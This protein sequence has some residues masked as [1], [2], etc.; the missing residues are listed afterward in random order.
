ML[1]TLIHY[2]RMNLAV[3][4]GAAVAT[5]VLTGALLVGDSVRGS[6][7]YLTLE[8]LGGVDH[9]LAGQRFFHADV[10]ER[11][12]QETEFQ[13]SFAAAA[14]AILLQG[15]ALHAERRTRASAVGLQGIDERFLEV[16]G[17]AGG[18]EDFFSG[19]KG[20]FPPAVI[21]ESLRAALQ[22]EVGDAILVSLKRWSEV[23]RGSV[24]GRKDT[25]SVVGT[26]RL[27]VARV[28]ADRGIGRFALA[29][30]QSSPYNVFVPLPALQKALDQEDTVNSLVVG[31]A[32][33]EGGATL[34]GLLQKVI[35]PSDL[36]LLIEERSGVLSLESQEFI[37]NPSLIRT[38]GALAA[39]H[40]APSLPILTYLANGIAIDDRR[41][42]YSTVTATETGSDSFGV[43]RLLDGSPA[44]EL[45][46]GEILLNAWTAEDLAAEV[47]DTVELSYYE[48]GPREELTEARAALRLRGILAMEG[49]AVDA[50]LSQEYPGIAGNEN[51]ADWDPPFPIDLNDIRVQDEDYWDT[52]RGTPKAFIATGTGQR[53]W[54]NRWGDLTAIRLAPPAGQDL[55][56]FR[57]DVE[58]RL[59]Q[60]LSLDAF[61]LTFQP[62]KQL[63]LQASAGSSDYGGYFIGFSFFLI[64]AAAM[65]V[66]L[67][68]GLGVEQ[69]AAEIGLLQAV[70]YAS[71]SVRRRLLLEG[72]LLAACG[73]LVGLVGAVGYAA[74]MM[75]AFRTWWRPAFGT[76]EL[77]LHVTP[78]SLVVGYLLSVAV[79]LFAIWRRVRQLRQVPTPALLKRV[80]EPVDTRAGRRARWT[81]VI[82]LGLA[83]VLLSIA[84]VTGETRNALI[85]AIAGPALLVG[86]LAAFALTLGGASR[87]L[88][89]PGGWTLLRM[90]AANG[91]RSKRR[92][93]LSATLV[94]AASFL[95]V[96]VAAFHHDFSLEELGKDSGS[97]GYALIGESDVPL[98]RDLS[99]RD[100]RFELGLDEAAEAVLAESTIT[101]LRL[102]PGDDTSC[103]NL[104]QPREPRLLGVP[105]EMIRRG[106]FVFQNAIQEADNPWSL[107]EQELEDGV[108]P[109]IGDV[110]S[111]Q[112]ILKLGLGKD[113]IL[114]N[115]RGEDVRIRLVANLKTS[116]FQSELL[117][118]QNNFAEHFPDQE[119]ASVFLIETPSAKVAETTQVLESSLGAYGFDAV[120]TIEKLTAFHAVQNTFLSTFRTLGGLGLLLGTVGLAIVLLRNV[121]ERRG[122]LAA[123]RAFG[124]RR[125]TL[126]WMVL[127]ENGL[128]LVAGLVIGTT[129]ALVT[130]GPHLLSAGATVPWSQILG[131]LVVILVFGLAACTAA[132]LG[133]L[134]IP[135]LPALKAEH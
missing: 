101:P 126:T 83:L 58:R 55:A 34:D 10:A 123:L 88:E 49:L 68:F 63:G 27:E 5:A 57:T 111:T 103:L 133:A 115:G 131:T 89:R 76:S 1:R 53:L 124:Y 46:D 119:G 121:I 82:A 6:L 102:L 127:V 19:G 75:V 100:G 26:V 20:I 92:S 29:A 71:G 132:S 125:A 36:G 61:G 118:S 104:Y 8:R 15:S 59:V 45:D 67:L 72:G 81:S 47:G 106:G 74:L 73:A 134:R 85:F 38:V 62:V 32:D 90:A 105:A 50:T 65:L 93:L 120:T 77:F 135:L 128:L 4:A 91:G 16:F 66:V 11:L 42:P 84:V 51:M 95:I 24:L 79:V 70:G 69:R 87:R 30:H 130:A 7:R 99:S 35:E 98:L 122:E 3:V 94:A 12:A 86:L 112:Y 25:A 109:A 41:V 28:I 117:I 14:P 23:P 116:I 37:L 64:V 43:L 129:A 33:D 56:A 97:G 78:T 80:S 114:Q 18:T 96:T 44:P 39:D 113:L 40:A 2:W 17:H 107:L 31:D 48:V 110:N 22:A 108:I 60:A 52:Y 9:A 13:A 21:N 54:Q